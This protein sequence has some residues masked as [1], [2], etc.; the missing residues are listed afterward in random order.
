MPDGKPTWR[1]V[2]QRSP[3]P[4]PLPVAHDALTARL[5][6]RAGFAA[7][8]I[9]GFALIGSHLA[10]PDADLSHFGEM[11][12]WIFDI[13]HASGLPVMV[14]ASNG[15]LD[16]KMVARTVM[17]VEALGASAF[18]LEDQSSPKKCGHMDDKHLHTVEEQCGRL[19]LAL[20][21]IQHDTFV[22]ART[23]AFAVEGM[24][25]VRR[26]CDAYLKLGVHGL[27]AEG[28]TDEADLRLFADSYPG[29][30]L[31]LSILEGHG[32]TPWIDP[33]ALGD[34]GYSMVLYPTSLLFAAMRA[35]IDRLDGLLVGDP[36]PEGRGSTMEEY[37][38]VVRLP[39][40]QE[41]E[42]RGQG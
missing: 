11:R 16:L 17:S 10:M 8:Q 32:K 36:T 41:L 22:M 21:T 42:Q 4:L 15:G 33:E 23:D 34:M 2:L 30:P 25:G 1:Q 28:I 31:A 29:V 9:G 26:R 18:F 27:Y 6:E 38:E 7:Y 5:I 37:G 24:D 35:V 19:R 13:V 14:D 39:W 3:L 20:D 40:W 12:P